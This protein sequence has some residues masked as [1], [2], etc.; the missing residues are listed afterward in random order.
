MSLHSLY[1]EFEVTE[2]T[3]RH[4]VDDLGITQRKAPVVKDVAANLLGL[5]DRDSNSAAKVEVADKPGINLQFSRHFEAEILPHPI[6]EMHAYIHA[7]SEGYLG[8]S[9]FE[10]WIDASLGLHRVPFQK[11]K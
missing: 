4:L 2:E 8:L 9:E 1:Y 3:V 11:Y 7:S 10:G 5:L 6:E